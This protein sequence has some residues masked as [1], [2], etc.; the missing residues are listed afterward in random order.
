QL[1]ATGADVTLGATVVYAGTFAESSSNLNLNGDKLSLTGS[2]TFTGGVIDG[3]GNLL[4]KGNSTIHGLTVAGGA[5]LSNFAV[6]TD[7]GTVTLGDSSG[8]SGRIVNEA[9]ATFDFVGNGRI[10]QESGGVGSFSN[11]SSTSI[12]E[13]TGGT[14]KSVVGVNVANNG[15][16]LVSSGT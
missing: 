14:G 7:N 11:L 10:N 6:I 9:G 16:V 13:K 8:G 2:S 3:P 4:L 1:T 15:E 12:L 5:M